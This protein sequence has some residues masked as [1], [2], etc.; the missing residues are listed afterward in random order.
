MKRK[1]VVTIFPYRTILRCCPGIV[2][3]N[4]VHTKYSTLKRSAFTTNIEL[5]KKLAPDNIIYFLIRLININ[6][7]R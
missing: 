5:N 4:S 6:N 7:I 1:F 3:L 2:Y